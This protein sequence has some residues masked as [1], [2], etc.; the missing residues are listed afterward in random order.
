MKRLDKIKSKEDLYKP[1]LTISSSIPSIVV[2]GLLALKFAGLSNITYTEIV[3][4]WLKVLGAMVGIFAV[5]GL[6]IALVTAFFIIN[7]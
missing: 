6:I 4:Y 3:I 2:G 7:D 5:I 1:I